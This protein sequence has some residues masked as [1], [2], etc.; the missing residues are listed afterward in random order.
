MQNLN[1][2]APP[3]KKDPYAYRNEDWYKAQV[4]ADQQKLWKK[5]KIWGVILAIFFTLLAIGLQRNKDSMKNSTNN[6]AATVVDS[7]WIP[8][9]Y[10]TDQKLNSDIAFSPVPANTSLNCQWCS[11]THG[12]YFWKVD[13]VSKVD[14]PD[15]YMLANI[16]SSS[17]VFEKSWYQKGGSQKALNPFRMEIVS[18]DQTATYEITKLSCSGA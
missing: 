4:K 10:S 16:Y 18:N 11:S 14:C 17:H 1:Y 13:F 9:G 15:F 3:S 5:L 8:A 6:A 7:S 12:N 2:V